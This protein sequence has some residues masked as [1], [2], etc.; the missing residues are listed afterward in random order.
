MPRKRCDE[1]R[2]SMEIDQGEGR[3]VV[4][5]G[6]DASLNNVASPGG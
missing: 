4:V 1:S 3:F 2:V 6:I 5:R